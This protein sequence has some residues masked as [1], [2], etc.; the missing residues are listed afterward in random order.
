MAPISSSL[1]A[2]ELDPMRPLVVRLFLS[3]CLLSIVSGYHHAAGLGALSRHL[4]FLAAWLVVQ[5]A[6]A[7]VACIFIRDFLRKLTPGSRGIARLDA[8]TLSAGEQQLCMVLTARGKAVASEED[9]QTLYLLDPDIHEYLLD[10]VAS[11]GFRL[12]AS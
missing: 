6:L 9:G 2:R 8:S 7:L 1:G 12:K 5:S 10:S 3:S 11:Q 4:V